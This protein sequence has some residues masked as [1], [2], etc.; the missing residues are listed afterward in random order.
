MIRRRTT[1]AVATSLFLLATALIDGG[2]AAA[3]ISLKITDADG[4]PLADA[5][6]SVTPVIKNTASAGGAFA[7]PSDAVIDQRNETFVPYVVVIRRG[8]TVTFRNSDQTRHHVYSFSPIKHFEYVLK[9]KESSPPVVF[10]K[11]GIVVLGCNIHDQMIAFIDVTDAPWVTV[12]PPSGLAR[13]DGLPSG[14]FVLTVWHPLIRP[15]VAPPTKTVL[16]PAQD[17]TSSVAVTID[18]P[19]PRDDDAGAY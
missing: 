3:S 2:A 11:P 9:P 8:G 12:T 17:S 13:I 4:H 6:V 7:T 14:D 19:R 1:A 18:P 5:V 16:L 10:D 15:G